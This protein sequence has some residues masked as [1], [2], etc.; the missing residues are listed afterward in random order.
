MSEAN[1]VGQTALMRAA[2]EGLVNNVNLLIKAGADVN[3]RDK[4][5]RSALMYAREGDHDA[6]ERLLIS[7][8]AINFDTK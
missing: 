3:Q 8:G 6:V 5:G 7:S 2:E 1:N 4:R